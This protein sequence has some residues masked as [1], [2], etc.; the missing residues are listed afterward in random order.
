M[1]VDDGLGTFC[2][3]VR[4]RINFNPTFH[5]DLVHLYLDIYFNIFLNYYILTKE[6][7][8]YEFFFLLG[9]YSLAFIIPSYTSNN[10]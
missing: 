8:R 2:I 3:S 6:E 5:S 1:Y 9:S 4:F 7:D 10:K